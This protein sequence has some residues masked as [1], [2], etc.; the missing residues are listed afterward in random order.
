MMFIKLLYR[1]IL[2]K[3]FIYFKINI[4]KYIVFV[5]FNKNFFF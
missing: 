3:T 5:K 4:E 1:I 2:K